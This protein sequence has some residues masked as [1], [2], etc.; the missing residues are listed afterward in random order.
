MRVWFSGPRIL[1]G[2]VRPGVS[3]G[4]SDFRKMAPSST[5][6]RWQS[7]PVSMGSFIYVIDGKDRS[8]IGISQNPLQKLM[9]LAA[10]SPVKL[11]LSYVGTTSGPALDM[12][13]AAN[14]IVGT[15]D[16]GWLLVPKHIAV[17]AVLE[18]ASKIG[19]SIQQIDPKMVPKI[20]QMATQVE[21][22]IASNR[23]F[24]RDMAI[25]VIIAVGVCL[26]IY[27]IISSISVPHY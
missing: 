20:I 26:L 27:R 22:Q 5:A 8:Q 24:R 7:A 9:E 13:Q 14:A 4:P 15:P 3:F 16:N 18:A 19:E 6:S 23:S 11:R 10:T 17:G 2:L 21:A 12:V 1:G 25:T